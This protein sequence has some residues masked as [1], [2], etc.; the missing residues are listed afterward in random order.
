MCEK[1]YPCYAQLTTGANESLV[2]QIQ[3]LTVKAGGTLMDGP[4]DYLK[5]PSYTALLRSI[6]SEVTADEGPELRSGPAMIRL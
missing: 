1:P 4:A 6:E 3:P 5:V 2:E